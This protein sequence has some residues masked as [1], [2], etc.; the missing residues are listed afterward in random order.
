MAVCHSHPDRVRRQERQGWDWSNTNQFPTRSTT[1]ATTPSTNTQSA[2]D[3]C[4]AACPTTPEYN[5]QCG[6]NQETNEY[7]T[8]SN[9]GRLSCARRC[10]LSKISYTGVC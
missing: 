5:P 8:Y 9:P 7:V 3:I 1:P 10:G 6:L 4:M 2:F